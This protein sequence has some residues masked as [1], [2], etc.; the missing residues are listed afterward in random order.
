MVPG[1][2][3]VGEATE[4]R[5][6]AKRFARDGNARGALRGE[7]AADQMT[8]GAVLDV[9]LATIPGAL[10]AREA[11]LATAQV[12]RSA[13][14]ERGAL[15]EAEAERAGPRPLGDAQL[16][17]VVGGVRS[18]DELANLVIDGETTKEPSAGVTG[19]LPTPATSSAGRVTEP[20]PGLYD[21]ID[22]DVIPLGWSIK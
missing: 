14:A 21:S 6:R 15:S 13:E 5:A 22:E 19:N 3:F 10:V 2:G 12:A 20:V 1:L 11:A 16:G 4:H 18:H 9:A 7:R 17:G 8:E